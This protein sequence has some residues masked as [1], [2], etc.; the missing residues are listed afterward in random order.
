MKK[1]SFDDQ[2]LISKGQ[3][4]YLFSSKGGMYAWKLFSVDQHVSNLSF[5]D[6]VAA[7]MESYVSD[8]LKISDFI[9][10]PIF[11]G[12]YGFLKEF[13]SLLLYFCYYS[14]ISGIDEIISVIKLLEWLLW[15]S[16]FT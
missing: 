9:I 3:K 14:L 8:F 7:Y 16:A 4:G 1:L 12:E 2:E 15:K 6:P 13:M 11:M 5:K 10:S